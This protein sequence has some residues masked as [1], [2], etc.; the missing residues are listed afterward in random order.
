MIVRAADCKK[1]QQIELIPKEKMVVLLCGRNRHVH[2]HSW[3]ALDGAEGGFDIKLPDTKGCQALTTGTLRPGG[4]PC[5]LAAVKRQVLCYEIT[6]TKPHHKKL[7]DVQAPGVAQWLGIVRDRLCMGYPSGFALLPLLGESSPVSLV[8]P[9]DPSLSFLSQQPLDALH[10]MEVGA[11]EFLL[12]FSQL[13]VYVDQQGRRSRTQELMWPASPVA[14]STRPLF[15]SLSPLFQAVGC[16][17]WGGGRPLPFKIANAGL[18]FPQPC[19]SS[20]GLAVLYRMQKKQGCGRQEV[21][22]LSSFT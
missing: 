11:E 3:G 22:V 10:A 17:L 2:L 13:G 1:V 18:Q 7:W 20:D 9:S 14:C 21:H 4:P 12:C 6:R 15:P 8:S 19:G 5:L 16:G